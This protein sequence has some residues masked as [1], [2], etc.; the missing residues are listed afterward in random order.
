[1]SS[2]FS[3]AA[4][5]RFLDVAIQQGLVN[6]NTGGGWKAACGRIL[7]DVADTDDIR[8]IDFKTAV[9]RYNNK[10]PG[11]LSP[12]SLREYE[13]RLGVI[14]K[15]FVSYTS[16]PARYK[17]RSRGPALGNGKN[18]EAKQG[19]GPRPK[20]AQRAEQQ[21]ALPEAPSRPAV[22][23]GLSLEFPMRPDFLAQVV[24]PRDMKVDEARRF[25]AFIMTLASDFS[26]GA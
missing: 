8:S 9:V 20:T 18:D 15:E 2:Q 21:A 1:M 26:P 22:A 14:T 23:A 11:E 13:R 10:H 24:V 4:L 6:A 19:S 12:N 16:D 3:K 17:P 5:I 7:E 25:S